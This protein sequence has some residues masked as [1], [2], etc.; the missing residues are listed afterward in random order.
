MIA[1]GR[2]GEPGMKRSVTEW[3]RR[4]DGLCREVVMRRA[5]ASRA[6]GN[7]EQWY[8][9]CEHC[10]KQGWLQWCHFASRRFSA[11]R[12]N[13]D[14][15]F[16]LR[17]GC[18]YGWAHQQPSEFAAWVEERLGPKRYAALRMRLKTPGKVDYGATEAYLLLAKQ[19]IVNGGGD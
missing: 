10:Q 13:L 5:G 16:A 4:L 7:P 15:C 1:V 18:H 12:W 8:G 6:D 11:L 2:A 17:A 3:K 14:N 19:R 9:A